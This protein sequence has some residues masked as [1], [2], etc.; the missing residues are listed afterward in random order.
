LVIFWGILLTGF[1]YL[2]LSIR[3]NIPILP[4]AFG[5]SSYTVGPML[6]IFLV[7]LLGHGSVR[8][9]IIGTVLSFL[10][11]LWVRTDVW[12]LVAS[13]NTPLLEWLGNLPTYEYSGGA[14]RS[15]YTFV[16]TWPLTTLLT[17]ACGILIPGARS[18]KAADP[19]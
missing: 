11:V 2:M 7:A 15:V 17:L 14:L 8:G 3:E 16:W 18:E 12:I 4:L 19:A 6:A 10:I 1:T 9:L 13:E 5:M